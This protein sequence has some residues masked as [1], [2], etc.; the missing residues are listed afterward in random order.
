MQR[1]PFLEV[2]VALAMALSVG[3]LGLLLAAPL[4]PQPRAEP[5]AIP[6]PA[7]SVEP[8]AILPPVGLYLSR[9]P[10]RIG[11]C[12]AI[13]REPHSYPVAADAPPDTAS[14]VWWDRGMTGCDSR[15]ADMGGVDAEVR[16][17]LTEEG[18]AGPTGYSLVFR[19][20]LAPDGFE[21]DVEVAILPVTENEPSL[22]QA[23]EVSSP[24]SPGLVLDRAESVDP[25]L[26]PLPSGG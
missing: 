10:L 20:P 19:L 14:V 6:T 2:G 25:P 21:V 3:M 4:L 11:P 13:E 7:A 18:P 9:T 5:S 24:G 26:D 1:I 17:V 22:L 16:R 12:F 8:E 15:S 23:L